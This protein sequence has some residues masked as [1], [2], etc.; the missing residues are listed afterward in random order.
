[1]R[2]APLLLLLLLGLL[3]CDGA[4]PTDATTSAKV[5]SSTK[6]ST[7]APMPTA[8][9]ASV[10]L[11]HKTPGTQASSPASNSSLKPPS[12]SAAET[13]R[14]TPGPSSVRSITQA[15]SET[16]RAPS[17]S[18]LQTIPSQM[19]AGAPA[20]TTQHAGSKPTSSGA[21]LSGK[22]TTVPPS[23]KPQQT[24][25]KPIAAGSAVSS[26]APGGATASPNNDSV[27]VTPKSPSPTNA[28][29]ARLTTQPAG[30]ATSKPTG[31]TAVAPTAPKDAKDTRLTTS[32]SAGAAPT[33][34]MSNP[35]P[36]AAT[37]VA[38]S[39]PVRQESS[40]DSRVTPTDA[41]V[42]S[43]IV[44]VKPMPSRDKVIVLTLNVSTSCDD[45]ED[46]PLKE[47]LLDLL[48]RAVK[49]SFNQNQDDCTVQMASTAEN[50]KEL[51][52]IK[53]SVT[54]HSVNEVLSEALATK[55][56][57]MEKLGVSNMTHSGRSLDA[58][59][60]F[61]MP[62]IITIVCM[63]ALLLLVAAIYGC[64]HQR[65]SHRKD[66]RL[67]EELQ[68]MENGYHDNPT[69]EVMETSSEM[70]E[71][72]VNLNGEL[73]DSWIVPMDSLTKE[74]LDEEEDTHL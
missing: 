50:P 48:C 18:V 65:I 17:S 5:T 6:Q 45:L 14:T 22:V 27:A 51:A 1:M 36:P 3:S 72:K 29:T 10:T 37:K 58:E 19:S 2:S 56:G 71:K 69:L 49:P 70:Q 46:T 42:H 64:C 74:D 35:R 34:R 67:T 73:G 47:L 21:S 13:G 44:C 25:G 61:G 8:A 30:P 20:E 55:K 12:G 53:T 63:A 40:P 54:T 26:A 9:G 41:P 39:P 24:T 52:I 68:T 7:A 4:D 33:T 62:L 59:D 23:E 15:P 28:Q 32:P 43:K 66:Q 60:R 57:E 31:P 16:S 38:S 11:A